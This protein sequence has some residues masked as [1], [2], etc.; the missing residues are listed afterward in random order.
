MA[1][2]GI[3]FLPPRLLKLHASRCALGADKCAKCRWHKIGKKWQAKCLWP[4]AAGKEGKSRTWLAMATRKRKKGGAPPATR[5][6][7]VLCRSFMKSLDEAQAAEAENSPFAQFRVKLLSSKGVFS[8]W[9]CRRHAES[10]FHQQALLH[11]DSCVGGNHV[12]VAAPSETEFGKCLED[13]K[14]GCSAR[15]QKNSDKTSLMRWCLSES[16]LQNARKHLQAARAI[17]MV[18]DERHGYLMVRYRACSKDM[19]VSSGLLGVAELS[20]GKS[21]EDIVAATRQCIETFAT[22]RHEPAR[23]FKG[24]V[25][26]VNREVVANIRKQTEMIVTDCASAE[27]L[28]QDIGRGKRAALRADV[29]KIFPNTKIIGRDRAHASQRLLSR[30]WGADTSLSELLKD[31]VCCLHCESSW[32]SLGNI[33]LKSLNPIGKAETLN[34]ESLDVRLKQ[35]AVTGKESVCQKIWRS[36]T[37]SAWFEEEVRKSKGVGGTTL[38]AAQHRFC[39][40][41]KPLGRMVLHMDAICA[42]LTRVV[43]ARP[44]ADSSWAAQF[45]KSFTAEKF[46]LLGMLADM[47]DTCIQLTRF[48]DD[49]DMDVAQQNEQVALFVQRL[50]AGGFETQ[51]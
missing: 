47:A 4:G 11:L 42:V 12:S 14:K 44:G 10:R 17:I 46:L 50:E 48:L 49:E 39:S 13:L 26:E 20:S 38:S 18:R 2:D 35:E 32:T 41:S 36:T 33:C 19:V 3:M 15:K 7:C 30:P 34:I 24:A 40:F 6:G 9:R 27:I 51:R 28:A 5:M 45:V 37:Y 25:A 31:V 8:L 22:E 29:S 43:S 1:D 21:A 23:G 16:M